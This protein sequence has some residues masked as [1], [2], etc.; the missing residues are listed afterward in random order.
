MS[1]IWDPCRDRVLLNKLIS[2]CVRFSGPEGN[3]PLPST[4]A[5]L[6]L[7]TWLSPGPFTSEAFKKDRSKIIIRAGPMGFMEHM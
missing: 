2:T 7:R 5:A 3:I 6:R 4:R 1:M